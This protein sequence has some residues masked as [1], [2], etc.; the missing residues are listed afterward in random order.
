MI[1]LK[2]NLLFWISQISP[3]ARSDVGEENS[4]FTY[5]WFNVLCGK[6]CNT[7]SELEMNFFRLKPRHFKTVTTLHV[8]LIK[9]FSFDID[10]SS[11]FKSYCLDLI[12]RL[13]LSLLQI[14][15]TPN[16]QYRRNQPFQINAR[17]FGNLLTN[18]QDYLSKGVLTN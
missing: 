15:L 11:P 8:R 2:V 14:F 18:F 13:R 3:K 7:F 12:S 17:S 5:F 10:L 9:S 4:K 6:L 16:W 1:G